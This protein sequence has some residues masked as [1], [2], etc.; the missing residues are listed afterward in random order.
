MGMAGATVALVPAL[1]IPGS[2]LARL[3]LRPTLMQLCRYAVVGG[4]GT[5]LNVLLFLVARTWLDAVPANLVAIVLSTLAT[6]EANRRFTFRGERHRWRTLLQ[7]LGTVVFYASYG[8][9]V[10]MLL[11]MLVARPTQLMES[12]AV[13]A[14]SLFGGIARFSVMRLWEF[15]PHAQRGVPHAQRGERVGRSGRSPERVARSA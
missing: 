4:V 13:A 5:L 12:V 7:N 2:W 3:R 11:D 6:T 8:A 14:A 9:A 15:A 10:L 1:E